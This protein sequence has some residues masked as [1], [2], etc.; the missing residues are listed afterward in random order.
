MAF[1]VWVGRERAPEPDA[2]E[3]WRRAIGALGGDAISL[4][5]TGRVAWLWSRGAGPAAVAAPDG[6][7]QS[8]LRISDSVATPTAGHATPHSASAAFGSWVW[9]AADSSSALLF[10]DALGRSL[11][12]RADVRGGALI[13]SREAWLLAFPGLPREVDE[14]ALVAWLA[15]MP[16]PAGRS[17]FR[18][19]SSLAPGATVALTP[20]GWRDPRAPY[21][22][23][24]VARVRS[25]GEALAIVQPLVLDAVSRAFD[26]ARRPA[27]LLS[28]GIDS[29]LVAAAA[30][31]CG[32][33]PLA[34]TN[35]SLVSAGL[36]ERPE[37]R[38]F[39]RKLG[40]DVVSFDLDALAPWCDG[41][42]RARLPDHPWNLV[43]RELRDRIYAWCR[44]EG[45]DRLV[46]GNF[47]DE[48]H[49]QPLDALADDFAGT[50]RAM[51]STTGTIGPRW[52]LRAMRRRASRLVGRVHGRPIGLDWLRKP[53]REALHE[54]FHEAQR[55]WRAYPR[56]D[57]AQF[58]RDYAAELMTGRERLFGERF[59][60]DYRPAFHD[61]V[62]FDAMLRL[63][64]R[65]SWRHGQDKWIFASIGARLVEDETWGRKKVAAP[66][67]IF[68][69]SAPLLRA[70]LDAA[71]G[72]S[73]HWLAHFLVDDP[74]VDPDEA[75]LRDFIEVETYA[76]LRQLR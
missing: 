58:L 39:A 18:S 42:D 12:L 29:S 61:P 8:G 56:P 27:L 11:L 24:I 76:W 20:K 5:R 41:A 40:L 66:Q 62:L 2:V 49:A 13:A 35:G 44:T 64:S 65:H 9:V 48:L 15:Q 6:S 25:P 10:R 28:S 70:E 53:W 51:L 45:I 19:I 67:S 57:Q 33:R 1:A 73:G 31:A 47:G 50:T 68:R 30:V 23:S 34:I 22:S 52:A 43:Y 4:L 75:L 71:R 37:A 17:L 14:D 60:V 16:P 3:R 59:G 54:R 7:G 74:P 36:E 55:A 69:E 32:V 46:D 72:R 26:G 21:R 63:P 38:R